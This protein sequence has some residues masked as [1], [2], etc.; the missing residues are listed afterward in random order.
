V[1]AG[2]PPPE[3]RV[4]L[5]RE[6]GVATLILD[7]PANLNAIDTEMLAELE[8]LLAEIDSDP[9]VQM[10]IVTGSRDRSFSV[11]ADVN[12]WSDLEP[13]DMWRRWIR[14]GHRVLQRLAQLRQPSIAAIIGYTFGGG[15]S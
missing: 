8:R 4:V 12:A 9:R 14:D 13:L 6:C 15:W 2:E 7:R 10:A 5:V 3:G 11:G 1:T